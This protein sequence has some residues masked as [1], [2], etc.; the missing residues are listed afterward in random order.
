MRGLA[1]LIVEWL[2]GGENR[3]AASLS[4]AT[5]VPRNTISTILSGA[6]VTG[7]EVASKLAR[8]LPRDKVKTI[9][10]L[11]YPEVRFLI[12]QQPANGASSEIQPCC[13]ERRRLA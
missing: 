3:T 5:G 4:R 10:V 2:K 8:V 13:S 9:V 1:E 6:R 12:E 11:E 7:I